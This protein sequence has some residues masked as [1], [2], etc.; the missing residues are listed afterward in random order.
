MQKIL[1]KSVIGAALLSILLVSACVEGEPQAPTPDINAIKTEAV[2]TAMVE[3]TVQAALSPTE[4]PLP[5]TLTP[6]PSATLNTD[7][8]QPAAGSSSSGSSSSGGGSSSGGSS[9]TPIPTWTPDVYKCEIVDEDPLDKPQ[10]TGW[11]YDK[12]WTVRNV[13]IATWTA[14]DYYVKWLGG[15][16]ISP[17]HIYKLPYDVAPYQTVDILV[18]IYVP[19]NPKAFPGLTTRWAIINDNGDEICNFYHN[20]P[21][22]YPAPTKT[23]TP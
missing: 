4:T 6:L 12:I 21:S 11:I 5:P 20:I 13:G 7:A 8:V 2:Q 22:T 3:M 14:K 18:D 19:I 17:A 15:D 9:G 16:D 10:M 1:R 23:P